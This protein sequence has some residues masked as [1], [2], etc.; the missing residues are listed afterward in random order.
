MKEGCKAFAWDPKP[1][2]IAASLLNLYSPV[3]GVM[4]KL[5]LFLWAMPASASASATEARSEVNTTDTPDK[6]KTKECN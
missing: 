5:G 3:L 2:V 6:V 1:K 4:G